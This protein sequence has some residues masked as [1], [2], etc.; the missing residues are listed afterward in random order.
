MST[1]HLVDP[2]LLP[3]LDMMPAAD[4]AAMDL[5]ELR[6]ASNARYAFLGA[7]A[8]APVV[9]TIAGPG[10]PLEA[11]PLQQQHGS[12]P[13]LGFRFGPVTYC[14]DASALPAATLAAAKG[15]SLFIVDALRYTPHPSHAHLDLALSWAAEV[16]APQT[17]LTN[18]HIDMDYTTLAA[19]LPAGVEPAV[20]GWRWTAALS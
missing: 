7:P 14:N 16:A 9:H 20:D 12:I 15:S 11:V 19:S 2:E 18:L 10:G 4:L 13:S 5:G 3:L 17:V 1:R 8:I 6:V